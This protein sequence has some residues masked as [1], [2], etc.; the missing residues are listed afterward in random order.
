VKVDNFKPKA[1]DPL[2]QPG[3]GSWVGQVGTEGSRVR[4]CGDVAVVEL[5][6][7]R[8]VGLAGEGDL[9]RV[10]SHGDY[11]SESVVDAAAS[12]PGGG[13]LRRN[14]VPGDLGFDAIARAQSAAGDELTLRRVL[15]CQMLLAGPRSRTMAGWLLHG[16]SGSLPR[17]IEACGLGRALV[18]LWHVQAGMAV[19]VADL[20]LP[21]WR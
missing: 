3:E 9:I 6:S 2:H 11:A 13:V 8:F 20:S 15:V 1:G 5:C 16:G 7:Q 19:N 21:T 10:W 14:P 12:V 4:A 17:D 18:G